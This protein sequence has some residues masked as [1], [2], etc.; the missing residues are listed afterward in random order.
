MA[1]R[2]IKARSSSRNVSPNYVETRWVDH[3]LRRH[4]L[5]VNR[6]KIRQKE[7][8]EAEDY[9]T[10]HNYFNALKDAIKNH[11]ITP[12]NLW[13]MDETGFVINH[14]EGG[15]IVTRRKKYA[16]K[17]G[18]P[19]NR[20]LATVIEAVSAAGDYIKAPFMILKAK[21]HL[22][23]WYSVPD[24]PDAGRIAVTDS[25]KLFI[26]GITPENYS[27]WKSNIDRMTTGATIMAT[28]IVQLSSHLND[29]QNTQKRQREIRN[30]RL[31][32]LQKGGVIGVLE[33]REMVKSK[34]EEALAKARRRV[35]T[36]NKKIEKQAKDAEK[37]A[38]RQLLEETRQ[39]HR[40]RTN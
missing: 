6:A 27:I 39:S 25:G 31:W 1:N 36:E 40:R 29:I 30:R 18:I 9:D 35:D 14:A 38:A 23:Q 17:K 4:H 28:E 15:C 24:L 33:G 2:I 16:S 5:T 26:E 7:R 13:N 8:Q 22:G 37:A 21:M 20:E 12:Q 11:G 10:I 34:D 32:R 19:T 3:F